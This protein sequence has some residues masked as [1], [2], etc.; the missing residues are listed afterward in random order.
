[1]GMLLSSLLMDTINTM[2]IYLFGASGHAKVVA[3]IALSSNYLIKAFVDSDPNKK[4][5]L[6]RPVLPKFPDEDIAGI[7]TIGNN[8]IR[9][10]IVNSAKK[11]SFV[12]LFHPQS[13]VSLTASI[14]EGST[15]MAGASIN[16]D[17]KIGR[18]CI[19]N[20]NSSVDHDCMVDDYVH[21]SPNVALAGN[22]K[23]GE[24]THIGVGACV[25]QGI[26]IGKWC[27]IGAGCVVIK[28]IPNGATVVG[29]PGRVIK[30]NE[31]Y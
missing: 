7:V 6:E 19:I 2:E 16:A 30:T 10:N 5:F 12:R 28:D 27:V 4:I 17:V 1:M 22:V 15:V 26:T 11:V 24:G 8:K 20:T 13:I 3:E 29:N 25:I 21:L 23:V 31:I 9:K 18:H 14:G